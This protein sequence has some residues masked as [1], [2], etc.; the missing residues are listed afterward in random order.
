[1]D[2]YAVINDDFD[3]LFY[4]ILFEDFDELLIN[5]WEPDGCVQQQPGDRM[6]LVK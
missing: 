6:I 3:I 1:M 5:Q 4:F 2:V